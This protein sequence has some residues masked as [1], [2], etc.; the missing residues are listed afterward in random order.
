MGPPGGFQ[1]EPLFGLFYFGQIV[2][3]N[4][5][6][7]VHKNALHDVGGIRLGRVAAHEVGQ[8]IA[9]KGA[10]SEMGEVQVSEKIHAIRYPKRG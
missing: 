5:D 2:G 8:Q 9:G 3:E 7:A 1:A 4:I 10:V 6:P